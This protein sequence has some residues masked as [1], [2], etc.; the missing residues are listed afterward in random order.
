MSEQDTVLRT[1][2]WAGTEVLEHVRELLKDAPETAER[3]LGMVDERLKHRREIELDQLR[4]NSRLEWAWLGFRVFMALLGFAALAV[5][6]LIAMRLINS[7]AAVQATA[8]LGAG[9]AS[10]V[11]IFVTGRSAGPLFARQKRGETR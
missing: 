3:V 5:Y 7:G 1:D 6:A 4:H 11:A 2:E 10:V 8:A 9:A